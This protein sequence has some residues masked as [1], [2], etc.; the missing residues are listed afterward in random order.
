MTDVLHL[1]TIAEYA[2]L[3][4]GRAVMQIYR[5]GRL[6]VSLKPDASPLTRADSPPNPLSPGTLP[7]QDCPYCLRKLPVWI[8]GTG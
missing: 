2:A 7:G 6:E 8:T 3:E 4:A 5:S 1:L